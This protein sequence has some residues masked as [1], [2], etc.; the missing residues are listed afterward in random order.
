MV[1]LTY[2][3]IYSAV[4]FMF[5]TEFTERTVIVLVYPADVDYFSFLSS[6]L[7]YNVTA[8]IPRTHFLFFTSSRH[9]C[10]LRH[11]AI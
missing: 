9:L 10:G 2:A 6:F 1:S 11:S 3:G 8:L 4:F 7:C 5:H